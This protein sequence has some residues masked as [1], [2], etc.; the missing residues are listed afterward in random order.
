M[1]PPSELAPAVGKDIESY[2]SKCGT[3]WH[4]VLTHKDDLVDKTECKECGRKHKYKPTDEGVVAAIKEFKK[5]R[6]A[7]RRAA[8]RK[9][10]KRKA[11]A[12]S[13]PAVEIDE[14]RPLI[15]YDMKATYSID[16]QIDHKTFGRGVVISTMGPNKI[17]VN[18]LDAGLKTL[19]H[20]R[21]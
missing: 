18:F 3:V 7:E 4:V 12:A 2:C 19:M 8:K 1:K 17:N 21:M 20:S 5:A 14:S 15:P 16:D 13:V 6:A 11:A 10:T 9:S